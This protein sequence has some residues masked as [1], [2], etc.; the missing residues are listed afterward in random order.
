MHWQRVQRDSNAPAEFA[1]YRRAKPQVAKDCRYQCVYCATPE[2]NLGGIRMFHVE[3][4][5]PKSK[6]PELETAYT[7]LFYACPICNIYKG[8]DWPGEPTEALDEPAYPDPEQ[9]DYGELFLVDLDSLEV[10]GRYVATRYLAHRICLNRPH[11]VSLRRYW[12]FM[13]RYE[14]ACRKARQLAE[15]CRANPTHVAQ[16]T[17]LLARVVEEGSAL[18]EKV[19]NAQRARPYRQSDLMA[20][21]T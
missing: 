17:V 7:N 5:R 12:R 16:Y 14:E 18:S 19:A 4:Y 20:G 11:L 9:R 15:R 1:D 3:H 8:A 6:F 21:P 10:D 13:R 2:V